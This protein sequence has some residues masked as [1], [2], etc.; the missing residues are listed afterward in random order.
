[1]SRITN[2]M[3]I[4]DFLS[5][6]NKSQNKLNKYMNQLSTG[7][8]FS[9]I[10]EEPIDAVKSMRLDTIL[11]FNQQYQDNAAEGI[12]W[13]KVTDEALNEVGKTL[14]TL[15][16]DALAAATGTM[17]P[18]SR[19]KLLPKVEQLRKDLVEIANSKYANSYIFNGFKTKVKPYQD[20]ASL[21]P[22]DYE[23]NGAVST[24]KLEREVAAGT[25]VGVNVTGPEIGFAQMFADINNF[26][27]ALA[28]DDPVEI[29]NTIDNIDTHIENVLVA[30]S[31]VGSCQNRLELGADRLS[32]QEVTYTDI[33]S[34]TADTDVAET[35]MKYMNEENVFR[36]A[37]Q[38]GSR[39][40][41][42]TLMDFL[43]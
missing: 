35:I 42:P 21:I 10:S 24:G 6:Y 20:A 40:F 7:D 43:R 12:S 16:T 37:L 41:Q 30:R 8:K 5:N 32:A 17:T 18:E 2:N 4:S 22:G 14:R 11:S 36:L 34:K 15:R 23:A 38:T 13:L 26:S 31:Q 25:V 28:S 3:I 1:M 33:L 9:R 19:Q 29:Q 27:V 39:I